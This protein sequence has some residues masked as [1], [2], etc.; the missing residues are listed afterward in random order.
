M[1]HDRDAL[2]DSPA[3]EVALD[4]IE[5]GIAA[6]QP[7]RVVRESV[8][9][10]GDQLRVGDEILDLGAFETV[11]VLGAGKGAAHVARVL[12]EV[13]GDALDGG[14]VVTDNPVET[15]RLEVL[16]GDHPVPS[17]R[18]VESAATVRERA[19]RADGETLVLAAFTG[20]GSAL[21]PAPADGVSLSDLRAVTDALLDSGAPIEDVNAVRKHCSALKGGQLA[22]V[23]APATVVTLL[24]SDVVG[25]DSATIASGPT[26]PD[27]TTFADALAVLE[28]YGI[29]AP[30][31]VAERLR[32]GVAGEVPETP[33][34]DDAAFDRVRTHVLA[35]AWT[36][37]GAAREA[38]RAADYRTLVLSSRVTGEAREAAETHAAVAAEMVATGNP[39]DPPAVVLSGGETTVT[40][41]GDGDGGP[42][43]EFALSAAGSLPDGAVVA[44]VD[45]DGKDGK[46]GVAGALVDA[47]TV[48]DWRAADAALDDSDAATYLRQRGALVKTGPTGTNVN[49]LRVM[50][51]GTPSE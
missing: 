12:E 5:A 15:A 40:V 23:V 1:I 20:G 13:L 7:E 6:A 25:D 32:R 36:A 48:T 10:D 28:R 4:C 30:D 39:M 31:A 27:P 51:V 18:G 34:D 46:S 47:E 41:R 11:L 33:T 8:T 22:R 45:T 37:L 43:C 3:Q 26:V 21:L 16:P 35:D 44:S 49:D 14:V 2:A 17:E 29:D 42:N 19:T 50:V 38:A 9:L 24:F